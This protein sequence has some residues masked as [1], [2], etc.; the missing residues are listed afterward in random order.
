MC[1]HIIEN[2]DSVPWSNLLGQ[3]FQL[4][5]PRCQIFVLV[6]RVV[7]NENVNVLLAKVVVKKVYSEYL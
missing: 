5:Q 6:D 4:D 1:C 2:T 7:S 3:E